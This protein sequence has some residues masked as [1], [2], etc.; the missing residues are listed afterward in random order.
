MRGS[1]LRSIRPRNGT[2][3]FMVGNI[4][5]WWM[6]TRWQ[7]SSMSLITLASLLGVVTTAW[8]MGWRGGMQPQR[9]RPHQRRL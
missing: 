9:P 6:S 5:L 2:L 1:F 8:D 3:V 7:V 4:L